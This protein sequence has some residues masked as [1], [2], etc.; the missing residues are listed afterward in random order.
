[1]NRFS[2]RLLALSVG[3]ALA[4][5][6]LLLP[7]L[8]LGRLDWP[9][10]LLAGVITGGIVYG[11]V[12]VCFVRP[13]RRLLDAVS[14]LRAEPAVAREAGPVERGS[15]LARAASQLA[16]L[17]CDLRAARWRQ[18]RLAALTAAV[19]KISHDLRGVLSPM[20]LAAER[21]Q[22]SGDPPISRA[23]D[24]LVR[25][26]DRATD[27]LRAMMEYAREGQTTSPPTRLAL[28]PLLED[29]VAHQAFG[30][31]R[32]T[33]T[34]ADALEADA[35][36]AALREAIVDL[37]RNAVNA[38][39]RHVRVTASGAP[40]T[41]RVEIADDGPGLPQS[42]QDNLYKPVAAGAQDPAP[43]RSSPG[44]G[45]AIVQ[46]LLSASG[47]GIALVQTGPAGT[48]FAIT[49]S[50]KVRSASRSPARNAG[51]VA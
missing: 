50:A 6:A 30:T 48:V 49:L 27:M 7:L 29:V 22:S 17:R 18:A 34:V 14:E 37:L 16:A 43:G 47:G 26:V 35:D 36:P 24:M 28:R 21:L 19:G 33:L 46:D 15:E 23:G 11:G 1:M 5:L 38:G 41:V 12:L 25:T 2:T 32:V 20:L 45:L 3:V 40:G 13:M 4:E 31:A 44:L 42:V 51:P 9:L 10:C 8:A 39:A